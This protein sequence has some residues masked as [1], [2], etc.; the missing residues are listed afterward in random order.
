MYNEQQAEQLP[1]TGLLILAG[2]ASPPYTA[3][4]VLKLRGTVQIEHTLARLSRK[5]LGKA[6]PA[7]AT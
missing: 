6:Q 1:K 2:K 7:N 5:A 3:E 4:D